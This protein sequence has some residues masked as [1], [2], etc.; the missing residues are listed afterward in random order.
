MSGNDQER[1]FLDRV[2][3]AIPGIRGY[4][5]PGARGETDGA[6]RSHL[7]ERIDALVA[8]LGEIRAVAGEEGDV[9]MAD[10]LDRI[11][12][13][14]ARTAGSLRAADYSG[15]GFFAGAPVHEE[16]LSRI[17]AYDA[18]ILDDLELLSSDIQALKYE[19]IGTL[20][21][22]EVEGTLASIELRVVNRRDMFEASAG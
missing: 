4:R 11:A 18:A 8:R 22:R 17:C 1:A 14:F 5:D 13:R 21:L 15:C 2:G 12:E 6:L 3:A 9:D 20:T 19:T 7:A 10:D 16:G